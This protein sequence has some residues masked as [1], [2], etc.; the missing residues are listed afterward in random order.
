MS[1]EVMM[2]LSFLFTF[3]VMRG[4]FILMN[5]ITKAIVLLIS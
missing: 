5:Q 3:L 1:P 4:L 2:G